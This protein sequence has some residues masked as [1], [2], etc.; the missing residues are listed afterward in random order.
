MATT[1]TT[2]PP[3]TFFNLIVL[4]S[5]GSLVRRQAAYGWVAFPS[6]D[7]EVAVIVETEAEADSLALIDN[8][9]L[10]VDG[11]FAGAATTAELQP[12]IKSTEPPAYGYEWSFPENIA[13]LD[14][15]GGFCRGT[16]NVIMIRD[17]GVSCDDP[18]ILSR[19]S[20]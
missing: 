19:A 7:S 6:P 10:V 15:W 12:L 17:F 1:T 4:P 11:E 20:E 3:P 2:L 16:S 9:F 8:S 13:N 18:I 5:Q 14:G